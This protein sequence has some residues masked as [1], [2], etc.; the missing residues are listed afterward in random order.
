MPNESLSCV[1]SVFDAP[2]WSRYGSNIQER[3]ASSEAAGLDDLRKN[4]AGTAPFTVAGYGISI[5]QRL[6]R[7][8]T[9][10]TLL[11]KSFDIDIDFTP[12]IMGVGIIGFPVK[13]QFPRTVDEDH[14]TFIGRW[15]EPSS[16]PPLPLL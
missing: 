9:N 11:I 2:R 16:S 6:R 1:R 14:V 15:L 4:L 8:E 12:R 13:F 7:M 5:K 10:N 3:R